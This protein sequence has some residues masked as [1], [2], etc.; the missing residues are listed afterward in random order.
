[1]EC[2]FLVDDAIEDINSRAWWEGYDV[3]TCKVI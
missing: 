2:T 1:M 3:E